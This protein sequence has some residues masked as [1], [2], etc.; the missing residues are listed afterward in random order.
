ML[1]CPTLCKYLAA[2]TCALLHMFV[3]MAC[4]TPQENAYFSIAV[5]ASGLYF[6]LIF[7]LISKN[8][9]YDY[10]PFW[11]TIFPIQHRYVCMHTQSHLAPQCWRSLWMTCLTGS[12]HTNWHKVWLSHP[13]CS[14]CP[15]A[16]PVLPAGAHPS[17][18]CQ[19]VGEGQ[20]MAPSCRGLRGP[21]KLAIT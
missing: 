9:S 2:V 15:P 17:L 5:T 3:Y 10:Q 1:C 19:G 13:H 8:K 18:A 11:V 20:G 14:N 6:Q 4:N 21:R 7:I 16:C 12:R